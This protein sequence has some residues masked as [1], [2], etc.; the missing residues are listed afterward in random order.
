[1]SDAST[2]TCPMC[3][4]AK[5]ETMPTDACLFFYEC[6]GC[7][8]LLRP[9]PGDEVYFLYRSVTPEIIMRF[10]EN[11]RLLDLVVVLRRK[12]AVV[13]SMGTQECGSLRQAD[14]RTIRRSVPDTRVSSRAMR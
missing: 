12:V 4:T 6:T 10:S 5:A 13:T 9:K 7:G 14:W 2:I 8:A 1:M 11:R 3:G